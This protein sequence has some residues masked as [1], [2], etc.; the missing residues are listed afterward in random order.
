ML[1]YGSERLPTWGEIYGIEKNMPPK[2]GR[3][4]ANHLTANRHKAYWDK[5]KHN[6]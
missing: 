4:Q 6:V 1:I 2:I 3:E 5:V